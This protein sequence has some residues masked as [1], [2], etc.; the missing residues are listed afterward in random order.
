MAINL[1]KDYTTH[2]AYINLAQI[3]IDRLAQLKKMVVRWMWWAER[4][5]NGRRWEWFK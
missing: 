2:E 4:W 1:T 5:K 3:S